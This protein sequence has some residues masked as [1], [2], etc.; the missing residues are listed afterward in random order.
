MLK[1]NRL[2]G[3]TAVLTVGAGLTYGAR[4]ALAVI[5]GQTATNTD[6]TITY[7]Y[8]WSGSTVARRDVFIDAN[9]DNTNGWAISGIGA[10]YLLQQ[11]T[12][13]AFGGANQGDW[14]WN[15]VPGAAVS[16]NPGSP[17]T[18]TINR[19]DIGELNPCAEA[20]SL[21]FRTEDSAGNTVDIS[22]PYVH[23]FTPST[24]CSTLKLAVPSYFSV[25][26][27][28]FTE[29]ENSGAE[30]AFALANPSSGPGSSVSTSWTQ[31]LQRLQSHGI[32]VYGYI[33]SR[34]AGVSTRARQPADYVLDIDRWYQWY[35]PYL[36][37]LFIDEEYNQCTSNL[38]PNGETNFNEAQYYK[39]IVAYMKASRNAYAPSGGVKIILN[40]GGTTPECLFTVNNTAD[41]TQDIIQANFETTYASYVNFT[42]A[43]GRWEL[44][45]P[46]D[47]F[48][49]LIH[50][51]N[52]AEME[53]AIALA[54]TAGK[55][56]G[57]V[58]VTDETSNAQWIGCTLNGT[59]YG[60]WNLLPGRCSG[61]TT[62][63]PR[64]KQ[65]TD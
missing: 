29:V 10:D 56:A 39:N 30:L 36:T 26:G 55:H 64:M 58:S 8:S 22:A 46:R 5:S 31:Q 9:Q 23:S 54:R 53:N 51:A 40:P 57:Y 50:T 19:S 49:H 32:A 17:A 14:K 18:W 25:G 38:G 28:D 35:G 61:D 60:T 44:Q 33:K 65:L 63:W 13:Y 42:I 47:K 15:P 20:S 3:Y 12:L 34:V 43:A 62:Y 7:G 1:K 41:P 27:A 45:Y 24:T 37:G 21:V 16:F 59:N 52:R 6:S 4:P 2:L 48:W 11:G